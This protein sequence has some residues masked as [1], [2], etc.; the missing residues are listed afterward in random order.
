MSIS[1]SAA[2]HWPLWP[3]PFRSHT[4]FLATCYH[5]MYMHDHNKQNIV[6]TN[7]VII[8]WDRNSFTYCLHGYTLQP[9]HFLQLSLCVVIVNVIWPLFKMAELMG[10]CAVIC[11]LKLHYS[12]PI[13]PSWQIVPR[14]SSMK[15]KNQECGNYSMHASGIGYGRLGRCI[16]FHHPCLIS[17]DL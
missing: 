8:G 2:L 12:P 9:I 17:L 5:T 6:F 10:H 15:E 11:G 13:Q 7:E 4:P 3:W 16:P 1:Q 14:G